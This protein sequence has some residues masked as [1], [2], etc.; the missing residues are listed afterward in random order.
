MVVGWLAKFLSGNKD[1]PIVLDLQ[2]DLKSELENYNKKSIGIVKNI[3]VWLSK[4]VIGLADSVVVSSEKALQ[5]DDK[6]KFS[7]VRD[8]IDMDLF[9][10]ESQENLDKKIKAELQAIEKWKGDGKVLIYT[11]GMEDGKG[12]EELLNE[13]LKIKESLGDWKLIL[14]GD[15]SKKDSYIKIVSESKFDDSVLF[16]EEIGFFALSHFLKIADV[17]IDPKKSSTESSGKLMNYMAGGLPIICFDSQFN[18]K[19]LSDDGYYLKN[20]A[21]LKNILKNVTFS[22]KVM[23]WLTKPKK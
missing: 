12:V 10:N 5:S 15:G 19:R 18:R 22:K 14:Y 20:I 16:T 23:I 7:V 21:E 6:I 4:L 11:G 13:F 8:G 1:I 2:G 9:E 3:F 17:A